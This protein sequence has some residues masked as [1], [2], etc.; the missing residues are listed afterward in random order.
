MQKFLKYSIVGILAHL[1]DALYF[2]PAISLCTAGLVP[3]KGVHHLCSRVAWLAM[4]APSIVLDS[5]MELTVIK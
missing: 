2:M 5:G 1:W 4:L 3:L